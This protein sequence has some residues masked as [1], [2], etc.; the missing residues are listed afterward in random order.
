MLSLTAESQALVKNDRPSVQD[1][2]SKVL[3]PS[4]ALRTSSVEEFHGPGFRFVRSFLL[5]ILVLVGCLLALAGVLSWY[6]SMDM[7]MESKGVIEPRHRHWVK[8]AIAG[9]IQQVHV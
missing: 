1:G 7:T 8:A 3:N 5:V 6:F 9:I 2:R 4:A